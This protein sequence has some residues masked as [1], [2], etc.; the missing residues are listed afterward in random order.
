MFSGRVR[1]QPREEEQ[2]REGAFSTGATGGFYVS[3]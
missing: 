1:F 2:Q 3:L